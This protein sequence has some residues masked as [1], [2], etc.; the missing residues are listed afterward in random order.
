MKKGLFNRRIP[1][2]F[3]LVI[4]IAIVGISTL[5]IQKGIFYIG[6]AA[7]DTEPQN[8]TITN[9]TDTSFSA[10]FT[11]SGLVDAVLNIN[12]AKTG[13]SII[14]DDRDK[15]TG[16]QGKYYSHH[17]TVPNLLPET[18]YNF[19]L[20]IGGKEYTNPSYVIR[21][22]KAITT[23]PPNQN[24]LFGKI[25]LPDGGVGSD[26]VIIAKTKQAETISAITDGKGEFILPT[27][28]LRNSLSTEYVTLQNDTVFTISV[29]RQTMK[30]SV[31][32]TFLVGQN[33]PPVTLLQQYVFSQVSEEVSTQSSQ[34]NI[35]FPSSGKTVDIINPQQGESF[36]DQRPLFS[37]TSYPNSSLTLTIPGVIEQQLLVK[38]DGSWSYQNQNGIPQGKHTL[39]ITT[40]DLNNQK[41]SITRNF[42]IFPQGSQITESA[43]PSATPSI[44]PTATPTPSPTPTTRP[45]PTITTTVTLTASPSVPLTVTPTLTPTATPTSL[46]TMKPTA[47]YT[48]TKLPPIAN[49]GRTGNT[50]L[51]T[52]I[53]II[54]IVAGTALLFAL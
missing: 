24:P 2:V 18:T 12:D 46:P 48:P 45:S 3:A 25:L 40:N 8:F 50:A 14:L 49:P 5:L 37:G 29:F 44:K 53:S 7:P 34:L 23:P 16:A 52:G 11:T 41:V 43:T 4:L 15:K 13:N 9:V 28:S 54:L 33:L 31:T 42:T 22:G 35:T 26:S 6:K 47:Y 38:A 39:T 1:T 10:V 19:K 32:A 20:L 27:N 30:A 21:T 17:I 51:L 36:V